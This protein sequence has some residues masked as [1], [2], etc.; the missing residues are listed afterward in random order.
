MYITMKK[1][2]NSNNAETQALNIPVVS[3]SF[4]CDCCG[5]EKTGIKHKMYDENWNVQRGC[6]ECD[7][8]YRDR[9]DSQL[10]DEERNV[11]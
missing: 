6:Y 3:K 8:C 10:T 4:L 5:K 7:E 2:K 1:A 11:C 9:L